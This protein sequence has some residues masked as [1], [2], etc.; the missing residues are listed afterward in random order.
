MTIYLTDTFSGSASTPIQSHT[1]DS[2]SGYS[3]PSS[4]AIELD[5]NGG[6]YLSSSGTAQS[7]SLATMPTV[8]NYEVVFELN[9]LTLVS[10]AQ[11]GVV[12]ATTGSVGS[13]D[14]GFWWDGSRNKLDWFNNG[15]YNVNAGTA[16]GPGVGSSWLIKLDLTVDPN[17]SGWLY[18]Y[19]F[20]STDG[21]TTYN[22]L[23]MA[24]NPLIVS[25]SS[26]P[27]ISV[28]LYMAGTA[29]TATTGPHIGN[30]IIQDVPPAPPN[31]S[32]ATSTPSPVNASGAYI[33]TSGQKAVF[34]FATG[35][36]GGVANVKPTKINAL[37]SFFKN[38]VSVGVGVNP[39]CTGLHYCCS[40]DLPSG[41]SI[42]PADTLTCT[43]VDSWV[44]C[45]TGNASAGFSNMTLTNYSG[46]SC[47]NT[48]SLTKTFKPG[49]NI[50]FLGC[51]DQTSF[52]LMKNWCY[53]LPQSIWSSSNTDS[54]PVYFVNTD[55][56]STFFDIVN[57]NGIDSVGMPG[58]PGYWAIGFDDNYIANSGTPTT[59]TLIAGST[60]TTVTQDAI[61]TGVSNSGTNGIGQFYMF[62]VQQSSSAATL[63]C[64]VS[65]KG[66]NSA[67]HTYISNLWIVGPGDFT[68]T[69][70]TP[71]TFDRS[72]R[73]AF[74][75]TW[76]TRFANSA[77]VLRWYGATL[78]Y[79]TWT[80]ISEAWEQHQLADF[81]WNNSNCP[82]YNIGFTG[83]RAIILT[84]SPYVYSEYLG[85]SFG[86]TLNTSIGTTDTTLSINSG[87]DAFAIPIAGLL[88]SVGTE[89]MRIRS[90]TGTS[91]PYSC[92]V[93]RGSSGTTV[94]SHSAG[95]I[96]CYGRLAI[97][98]IGQLGSGIIE[99]VCNA[100]HG[101][102]TGIETTFSGSGY[103]SPVY[104]TDGSSNSAL[105]NFSYPIMVT[106]P[107][108]Y[109][110][111]LRG[112][113]GVTLGPS[114]AYPTAPTSYALNPANSKFSQ[115][116]P[117][118]GFPPEI[119]AMATG[120][121]PDCNL[122]VNIPAAATDSYIYDVATK[123]LNYFPAGRIVYIELGDE[124]W[125][126]GQQQ[127]YFS[128]MMSKLFG[129]ST[130]NNANTY[131]WYVVRSGQMRAIFRNV[132]GS[133]AS[134]V[135]M[136]LN[137]QWSNPSDGVNML[138]IAIANSVTV[139][140]LAG[141]A[142]INPDS[143]TGSQS[144]TNAWNGSTS[145]AQMNDLWV[146]DLYYNSSTFT[147]FASGNNSAINSYNTSTGGNCVLYGYEGGFSQGTGS[148]A[149]N[150]TTISHDM[151]Y[152][153]T[154]RV[155]EQDFY[156][157]CQRAGFVDFAITEYSAYYFYSSNWSVYH[158]TQQMAGAP[159]SNRQW[160]ATPG[161]RVNYDGTIGN[162]QDIHMESCRGQ[163][164][165]DWM[166]SF[167]SP[168]IGHRLLEPIPSHSLLENGSRVLLENRSATLLELPFLLPRLLQNN[169]RRK[170][171]N[172]SL[173]DIEP[174]AFKRR[175]LE[176]GSVLTLG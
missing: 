82:G 127:I 24:Q 171:E 75:N 52:N 54:Y 30:L 131:Y 156:A 80:N 57:G 10:G 94:A 135:K 159:L 3:T 109:A 53:R 114:T 128:S 122:H 42:S 48:S 1:S 56:E 71:L 85:S 9:M 55:I 47:F 6:I 2:G 106:G 105:Q 116:L 33:A 138:N 29:V 21:G 117:G 86:L 126:F 174:F 19:A 157:C 65:L 149:N 167:V 99:V 45:G 145:I 87:S 8:I 43:V 118:A 63:Q 125:N 172:G 98:S 160:F 39:W 35:L 168:L 40:V 162:S 164:F 115:N 60:D 81:S 90:V 158:Y 169:S 93:E 13:N 152:D 136:M 134:E 108:T 26:Y 151:V 133:R 100:N 89:K 7:L 34:F 129:A 36:S 175:L 163:A 91:N 49:F 83:F 50:S 110:I 72:Q 144:S 69:P 12:V 5:G 141:G 28:G 15:S 150:Q 14:I 121:L 146:H 153:P 66:V 96:S 25:T 31:C 139:D 16:N 111:D 62:N 137:S 113:S 166:S 95:A 147:G 161:F 67:K 123:I 17:D 18:L 132:F 41:V 154:W 165:L 143:G 51:S 124:F 84:A 119:I 23:G 142:Y 103:P 20:Y 4:G 173:R 78:G 74:S 37:P 11:T 102:K 176:N 148:H 73:H 38:G 59:L 140:V 32:V 170:L 77:G 101:L 130:A 70:G 104:L 107:T 155:I 120:A 46:I 76:N 68:Y 112:G 88:L 58:L 44:T 97:T 61:C 27:P 64:P 92:F 79:S 22:L